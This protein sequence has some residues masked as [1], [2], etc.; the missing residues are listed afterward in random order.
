MVFDYEFTGKERLV[1][2]DFIK[3]EYEIKVRGL[4]KVLEHL[5][6][7]EFCLQV[8]LFEQRLWDETAHLRPGDEAFRLTS[9]ASAMERLQHIICNVRRAACHALTLDTPRNVDWQEE[10][11][12]CCMLYTAGSS[13][14]GYSQYE[15]LAAWL[16]SA[17]SIGKGYG[18]DD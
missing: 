5:A 8:I 15:R 11:G 10:F 9:N 13:N 7:E 3:F 17:V 14:F 1:V 6:E 16:A 18:A 4:A 12:F 2:W